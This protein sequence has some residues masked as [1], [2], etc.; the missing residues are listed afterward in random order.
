MLARLCVVAATAG[1]AAGVGVA[2]RVVAEVGAGS[3]TFMRFGRGEP[4]RDGGSWV[5]AGVERSIVG[6]GRVDA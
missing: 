2:A 1:G 6:G 4:G 3:M 5:M